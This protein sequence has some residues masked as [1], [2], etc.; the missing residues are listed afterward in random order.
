MA[1]DGRRK[2]RKRRIVAAAVFGILALTL[3]LSLFYYAERHKSVT[4][5]FGIF[6]GSNWG[7]ANGDSYRII[8]KAILKFEKS[9]PGMHVHYYSGIRK[10]DYG[11]WLSQQI[12]QGKM[13]DV[14]LIPGEQFDKLADMGLLLDL[15]KIISKDGRIKSWEY[16]TNAWNSGIYKGTLFALPY[17]TD[18]MLMAVNKTLFDNCSLSLPKPDWTWNDFYDLCRLMTQDENNDGLPDTAGV[19]GYSWK[20]AAYSNGA[21]LF[22]NYGKR[23]YFSDQKVL[24]AVL[25]M[26]KLSS[27]TA[28]K[29]FSQKDFD[30]G[31][32][33]F[34][35]LSFAKYKT[36]ISYPYKITKDRNF[37]WQC[38]DMPAGYSGNNISEVNTLLAGISANTRHKKLALDFLEILTHDIEI[39]TDI[40]QSTQGTS[41]LRLIANSPYAKQLLTSVT[42]TQELGL[43]ANILNTG[44]L[45]QKF[46][47]FDELM[48]LADDSVNKIISE[49]KDAD[50]SLK[51]FQRNIQTMLDQ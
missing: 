13:C 22:D 23:A 4:L 24:E 49:K 43:I 31:R 46:T 41:A 5:E 17:E 7:V 1:D 39:Q 42:G 35:P 3:P 6:T 10:Q 40:S 34:M 29:I 48:V 2:A 32:V 28:N 51:I 12:L 21:R 11:E 16:F 26:Q 14:L 18:F 45:Q 38:L 47:N 25:F 36:Y 33:A 9:H 37:E 27:L 15:D 30:E 20:E 44:F 19:C 8:D 50:S